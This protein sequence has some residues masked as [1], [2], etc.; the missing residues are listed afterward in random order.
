MIGFMT[1]L[2]LGLDFGFVE[3]KTAGK[4][5]AIVTAHES[6][7]ISSST[8]AIDHD[9]CGGH[10]EKFGHGSTCTN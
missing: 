3:E 8:G 4:G 10:K 1:R 6:P 9:S 2:G 5:V 7:A